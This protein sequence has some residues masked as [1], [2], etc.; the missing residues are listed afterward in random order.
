MGRQ[1]ELYTLE[2]VQARD[3]LERLLAGEIEVLRSSTVGP[4]YPQFQLPAVNYGL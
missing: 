1:E 4:C 2:S 3:V